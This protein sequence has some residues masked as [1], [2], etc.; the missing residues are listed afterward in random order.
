MAAA[1]RFLCSEFEEV[2]LIYLKIRSFSHRQKL[3]GHAM[4]LPTQTGH[5]NL[6]LLPYLVICFDMD[7]SFPRIRV[8]Y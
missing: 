8:S 5:L 6:K 2:E 7:A 4:Q 1:S 3:P